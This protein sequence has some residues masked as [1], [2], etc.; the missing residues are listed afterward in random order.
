MGNLIRH[1][2]ML[3]KVGIGNHGRNDTLLIDLIGFHSVHEIYII[4]IHNE[5]NKVDRFQHKISRDAYF[6]MKFLQDDKTLLKQSKRY[7]YGV[8]VFLGSDLALYFYLHQ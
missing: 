3:R 1:L 6:S 7:I 8:M 5:I 4:I 2:F